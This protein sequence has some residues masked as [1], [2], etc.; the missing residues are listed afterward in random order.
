M[1]TDNLAI[2]ALE[3]NSLNAIISSCF[4]LSKE[5]RELAADL[6]SAII[7]DPKYKAAVHFPY[8]KSYSPP[9]TARSHLQDLVRR[10]VSAEDQSKEDR[11]V[12]RKFSNEI[13]DRNLLEF[14][15]STNG[16]TWQR[17][18]YGMSNLIYIHPDE[19]AEYKKNATRLLKMDGVYE[20]VVVELREP[21]RFENLIRMLSAFFPEHVP[22]LGL[23]TI[24]RTVLESSTNLVI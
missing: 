16:S 23:V 9:W 24:K 19:I 14:L 11:A 20:N 22:D 8:K 12:A 2:C 1:S 17:P 15:I 4:A 21:Y 10:F 13:G 3:I 5:E 18:F 6:L 7:K